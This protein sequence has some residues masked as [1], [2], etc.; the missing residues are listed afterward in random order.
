MIQSVIFDF[1]DTLITNV[2]L[3]YAGFDKPCKKL[4]INGLNFANFLSLRKKGLLAKDI[5]KKIKLNS[6]MNFDVSK[7]ISIR[8]EFLQ[9]KESV[10]FLKLNA[11][12]RNVLSF[13]KSKKIKCFLCTIRNNK[14]III[15]FLK[16]NNLLQY[17]S[18]IYLMDDI[19]TDFDK[20]IPSNRILIKNSLIYKVMKEHSLSNNVILLIG[21]SDD[22]YNSSNTMHIDFICY[23]N[24]HIRNTVKGIWKVTSMMDLKKKLISLV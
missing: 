11:G 3:D 18:G 4:G 17:F 15:K 8:N 6:K 19:I 20:S 23:D 16:R 12:A 2:L 10:S 24:S 5:V 21:N 1:D 7:F 22:D 14:K 9:S 13:L